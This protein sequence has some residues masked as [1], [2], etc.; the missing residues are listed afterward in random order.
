MFLS[1]QGIA[2]QGTSIVSTDIA[3]ESGSRELMLGWLHAGEKN[4]EI[5]A[6]LGYNATEY[7]AVTVYGL[8][9]YLLGCR[10][11]GAGLTVL[12]FMYRYVAL[13]GAHTYGRQAGIAYENF[14][15]SDDCL[16]V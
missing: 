1:L 6:G 14:E 8:C 12:G 5:F 10:G 9:V 2:S 3:K 16:Q 15:V 4:R 13:M 7:A 11:Q